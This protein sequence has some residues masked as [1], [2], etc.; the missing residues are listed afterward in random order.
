MKRDVIRPRL[1]RPPVERLPFVSDFSGVRLVMSS[2]DGCET[3]RMPGEVGL[4]CFCGIFLMSCV[5]GA[6]CCVLFFGTQ[7]AAPA[8]NGYT[9]SIKSGAFSPS[10]SL[11][12]DL[13][14]YR[15]L[16]AE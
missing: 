16:P 3:A 15:S 5:P 11:T 10:F 4:Y 1:L 14:Q 9:P 6:V 2:N 12:Y 7:H 13:R 8:F